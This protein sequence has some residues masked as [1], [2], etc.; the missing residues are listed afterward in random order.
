MRGYRG[1]NSTHQPR[2]SRYAVHL[3]AQL[4]P[5]EDHR[6]IS[7]S[8]IAPWLDTKGYFRKDAAV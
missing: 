3:K 4:T 5:L 8:V 7:W 6:Q 2:P 1:S